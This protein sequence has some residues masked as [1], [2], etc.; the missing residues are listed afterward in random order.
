MAFLSGWDFPVLL[1]GPPGPPRLPA[2]S[3]GSAWSIRGLARRSPCR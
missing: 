1:N 3:I 2:G